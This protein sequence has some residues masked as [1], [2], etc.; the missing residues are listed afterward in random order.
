MQT[1]VIEENNKQKNR[2][3]GSQYRI[4]FLKRGNTL[5]KLALDMH[6]II[7]GSCERPWEINSSSYKY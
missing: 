5:G 2:S 3:L 4:D 6:Q 7:S 1:V